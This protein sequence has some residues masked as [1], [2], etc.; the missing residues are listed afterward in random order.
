MRTQLE[1]S[2]KGLYKRERQ[3]DS[4]GSSHPASKDR[5]VFNSRPTITGPRK[6]P[7]IVEADQKGCA[8]TGME[9]RKA[10]HMWHPVICHKTLRNR[11]QS[12]FGK[13]DAILT[14]RAGGR[15]RRTCSRH[16]GDADAIIKRRVNPQHHRRPPPCKAKRIARSPPPIAI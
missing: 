2:S 9:G 13:D 15:N 3:I 8:V 6:P 14:A 10:F 1:K 16:S 12:F 5:D 4:Q 11:H 7:A